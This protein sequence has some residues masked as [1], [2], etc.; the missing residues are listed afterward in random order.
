[1]MAERPQFG[2]GNFTGD[3]TGEFTVVPYGNGE[4]ELIIDETDGGSTMLTLILETQDALD[5]IAALQRGIK[6]KPQPKETGL[7]QLQGDTLRYAVRNRGWL[8]VSS[9]KNHVVKKGGHPYMETA[10]V[11]ALLMG[12]VYEGYLNEPVKD[13]QCFVWNITDKGREAVE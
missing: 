1:M 9:V 3:L 4:V 7:T 5:L 8:K 10:D 6:W 11:H 2:A 12:L 13:H